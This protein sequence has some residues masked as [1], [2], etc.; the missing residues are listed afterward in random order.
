MRAQVREV[1]GAQQ[2]AA[3]QAV[4]EVYASVGKLEGAYSGV[5]RRAK[6]HAD[7]ADRL[8]RDLLELKAHRDHTPLS[9]RPA[10]VAASPDMNPE[11][12]REVAILQVQLHRAHIAPFALLLP[13]AS[14][15]ADRGCQRER[16]RWLRRSNA[17]RESS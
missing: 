8:A 16:R 12:G 5:Q 13:T 1:V 11:Q 2:E 4:D 17:I 14:C 6:R 3:R 9:G 15:V 7:D 10:D